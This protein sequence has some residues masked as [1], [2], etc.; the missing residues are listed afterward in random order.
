ML[1]SDIRIKGMTNLNF[2]TIEIEITLKNFHFYCICKK[3]YKDKDRF[4]L[5]LMK[6]R[7]L[8]S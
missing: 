4:L 8:H 7:G 2:N 6:S 3:S 1:A 5:D